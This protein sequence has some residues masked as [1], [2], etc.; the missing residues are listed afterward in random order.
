MVEGM[1]PSQTFESREI[2][3]RR[4]PFTSG[5][6]RQRGV[7]GVAYQVA[8]RRSAGAEV[9]EDPPMT[10]TR[11]NDRHV[12]MVAQSPDESHGI[13]Q[14]SG[15]VKDLWVCQ[16]AQTTSEHQFGNRAPLGIVVET[17]FQPRSVF[18]VPFRVL[19]MSI[20]ENV[21]V[22]KDH[23]SSMVSSRADVLSRSTPGCRPSPLNVERRV[24]FV[25]ETP[26]SCDKHRRRA[27]SITLPSVLCRSSA[28]C[29]ARRSNSS[30]M[31]TVVLIIHHNISVPHHDVKRSF[32]AAGLSGGER[33]SECGTADV[34]E[35]R[36]ILDDGVNF[37][38]K[39]F[40]RDALARKVREVLEGCSP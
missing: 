34:I 4:D 1:S 39:P 22:Q 9:T 32:C 33:A 7:V 21:H 12:G 30:C 11:R 14:G 27:S 15:R 24:G 26:V 20:D 37:L 38:S 36:G 6:H 28:S 25:R 5:L 40:G 31:F 19:S 8:S 16:D 23:R 18:G 17:L 10:G 35:Q 3:V 29:F 2:P 13:R